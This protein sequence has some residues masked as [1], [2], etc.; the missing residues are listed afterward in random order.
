MTRQSEFKRGLVQQRE[1][2]EL[3]RKLDRKRAEQQPTQQEPTDDR[4]DP[5]ARNVSESREARGGGGER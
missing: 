2:D 3:F 1:M 5:D 4:S